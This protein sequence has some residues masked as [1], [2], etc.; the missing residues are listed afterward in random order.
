MSEYKKC[1][2]GHFYQGDYCPHC[3][4]EYSS[5]DEIDWMANK[6]LAE[7]MMK[8]PV[9]KHCGQPLRKGIPHPPHGVVVSSLNDIRDHIVP[10]NYS[11]DGKCEHCGFDYNIY[12]QTPTGSTGLDNRVRYTTVK[13]ASCGVMHS[14]TANLGEVVCTDFSGVEIETK[15]DGGSYQGKI[16]LSVKELKYIFKYLQNSP[17]MEQFDY[18]SA[19]YEAVVYRT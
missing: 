11:W 2:N 3:P 16:F 12:M 14:I 17:L 15:T 13:C 19:D 10:W 7:R 5:I 6:E 1:P 4:R 9:C 8:I 18:M